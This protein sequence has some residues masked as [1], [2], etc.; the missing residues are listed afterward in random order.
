MGVFLWGFLSS[1]GFLVTMLFKPFKYCITYPSA[2]QAYTGT[3]KTCYTPGKGD[4]EFLAITGAAKLGT[5]ITKWGNATVFGLLF[6]FS[7]FSF[8]KTDDRIMQKVYYRFV[9]WMIPSSWILSFII[10]IYFIAASAKKTKALQDVVN[11]AAQYNVGVT[12]FAAKYMGLALV[13]SAVVAL[14]EWGAWM[15]REKTV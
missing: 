12:N 13:Y 2:Y 7:L 4:Q 14:I 3:S 15:L 5:W 11:G 6:L 10:L 8:I 1:W 9:A